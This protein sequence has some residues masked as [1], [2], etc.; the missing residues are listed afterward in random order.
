MTP[1]ELGKQLEALKDRPDEGIM[2]IAK[3]LLE[4]VELYE[5]CELIDHIMGSIQD[6]GMPAEHINNFGFGI[7]RTMIGLAVYQKIKS[8]IDENTDKNMREITNRMLNE[9]SNIST[10]VDSSDFFNAFLAT[11]MAIASQIHND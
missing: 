10:K 9:W 2:V 11:M 4:D 6:V 8:T 3:C 7:A 5:F 1:E